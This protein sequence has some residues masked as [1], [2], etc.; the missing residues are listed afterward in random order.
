[1]DSITNSLHLSNGI[2][3]PIGEN[4]VKTEAEQ[5]LDSWGP[6]VGNEAVI[7]TAS[8][9]RSSVMS[10]MDVYIHWQSDEYDTFYMRITNYIG[11][12]IHATPWHPPWYP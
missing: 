11:F 7:G 5:L 1:M 8:G 9:Q 6:T 3:R 4:V 10:G 12:S 2:G